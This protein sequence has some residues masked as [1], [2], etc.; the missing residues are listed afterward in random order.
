MGKEKDEKLEGPEEN[1]TECHMLGRGSGV[2]GGGGQA[3]GKVSPA[4]EEERGGGSR[5]PASFEGGG[6][7]ERRSAVLMATGRISK[8]NLGAGGKVLEQ[9]ALG[10]HA[11]SGK[12]SCAHIQPRCTHCKSRSYRK[13]PPP[14]PPCEGGHGKNV[15]D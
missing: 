11:A 5:R 9:P 14:P 6:G 15:F 8:H 12:L 10:P 3:V 2:S 1:F 13:S 4:L 7:R